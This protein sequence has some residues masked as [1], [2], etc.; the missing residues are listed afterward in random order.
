MT[1]IAV[2]HN[3]L[4]LHLL[5]YIIMHHDTNCVY[6]L[7]SMNNK[8]LYTGVTSNLFQRIA[9]HRQVEGSRFT[10][11][12]KVYKL[13]YY[14]CG[15]DIEAAIYREKQIKAGSREDKEKLIHSLNPDWKDLAEDWY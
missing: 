6:I 10:S 1:R 14:E 12:Y 13:V 11:K 8:V 5:E 2:W 15:G 7:S 3:Q 4:L 9:Q